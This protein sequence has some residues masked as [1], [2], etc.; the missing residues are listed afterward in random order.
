M[1]KGL[2]FCQRILPTSVSEMN[3]H[4]KVPRI[5]IIYYYVVNLIFIYTFYGYIYSKSRKVQGQLCI[6]AYVNGTRNK[7]HYSLRFPLQYIEINNTCSM[8]QQIMNI[9]KS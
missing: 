6:S 8:A 2:I 5:A 7:P 1:Y 3:L 9:H 4:C